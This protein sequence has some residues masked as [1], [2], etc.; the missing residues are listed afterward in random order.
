MRI[1]SVV[2]LLVLTAPAVK[3][4]ATTE[5][6]YYGFDPDIV[7]NYVAD[8]RRTLGY[9]RVSVEL[10]LPSRDLLRSI[11]YHEP[12]ILDSIIGILSKQPEQK[13][14]SLT[15]REEIRQQILEQLQLILKRETGQ[16]MIQDVLF[17]KY[18]YQ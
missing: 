13:I 11:E 16:T 18:M 9:V 3:A 10:M 2:L 1:L 15:G 12:I 4:Q 17:T 8:N 14:K 7:T 5:V 6:V